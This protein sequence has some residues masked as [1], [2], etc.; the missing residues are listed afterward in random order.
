MSAQR[1]L[2]NAFASGGRSPDGVR[3]QVGLKSSLEKRM[4]Q[5]KPVQSSIR[6]GHRISIEKNVSAMS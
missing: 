2:G 4:C 6:H 1:G 3:L 5:P